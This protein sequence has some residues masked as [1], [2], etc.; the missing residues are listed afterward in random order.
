MATDT[1]A[2]ADDAQTYDLT[3]YADTV[4][5]GLKINSKPGEQRKVLWH[6]GMGGYG[7]GVLRDVRGLMWDGEAPPQLRPKAFLPDDFPGADYLET[8][9]E[10]RRVAE[11]E[12]EDPEEGA[13][14]AAEVWE[15]DVR[16]ALKDRIV[17]EARFE[18]ETRTVY[19]IEYVDE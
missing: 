14:L 13:E 4:V 10:G 5:Q 7:E 6:K 15:E 2:A 1:D 3:V 16:R 11:E 12:G 17:V 18:E 8:R 19:N 9:A